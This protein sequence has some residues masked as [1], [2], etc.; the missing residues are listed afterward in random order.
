MLFSHKYVS[1][2]VVKSLFF[3]LQKLRKQNL[4]EK[5]L[6]LVFQTMAEQ[7]D[8]LGGRRADMINFTNI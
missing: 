7:L 2:P 1:I 8:R 6:F 4:T 3:K 5:I